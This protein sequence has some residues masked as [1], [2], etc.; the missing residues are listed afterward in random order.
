MYQNK[1]PKLSG[2]LL[3]IEYWPKWQPN[4]TDNSRFVEPDVFLRFED[5][6][7]L[8]EAK[9]RNY[10]G[11]SKTQY[12]N[13]IQAYSNEYGDDNKILYYIKLGG[14]IT[15]SNEDSSQSKIIICKTDWSKLLQEVVELK[16]ELEQS[17][18]Y[19]T[20]HYIRLLDDC[21]KG[22]TLHHFYY[23]EWL[24]DLSKIKINTQT[25]PLNIK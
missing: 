23:M 2:E 15:F 10:G 16:K 1:L 11:Q 7:V 8:I 3:S 5:F 12:T 18:R 4:H 13:Q 17:N 24:I 6:D 9:R 20:E 25:I 22:F 21:I 14:L 19:L